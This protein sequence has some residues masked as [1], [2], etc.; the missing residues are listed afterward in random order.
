METLDLLTDQRGESGFDDKGR[1]VVSVV[2]GKT[3][4]EP[5]FCAFFR[6]ARN[7]V[8]GRGDCRQGDWRNPKATCPDMGKFGC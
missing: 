5:C 1:G 2:L 4:A 8:V 3:L 7:R 6:S